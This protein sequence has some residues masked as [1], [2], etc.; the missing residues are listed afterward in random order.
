MSRKF[1]RNARFEPDKFTPE[2]E[3]SLQSL[4]AVIKE[5][6]IDVPAGLP[7]MASGLFGYLGYD[8]VRQVEKS[9]RR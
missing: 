9:C 8:M 6:R 7:P 4:R 3:P 5:S 2:A 1:N